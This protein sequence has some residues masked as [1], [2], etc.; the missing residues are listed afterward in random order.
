MRQKAD[1]IG[2]AELAII[3]M[4]K[5]SMI[6][7]TGKI[8]WSEEVHEQRI[9]STEIPRLLVPRRS[10]G[11]YTATHYGRSYWPILRT[12]ESWDAEGADREDGDKHSID[13]CAEW[14]PYIHSSTKIILDLPVSLKKVDLLPP[15]GGQLNGMQAICIREIEESIR[16]RERT[17]P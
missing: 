11:Q 10:N 5:G 3:R 12:V 9:T 13:K 8:T 16:T 2:S 15:E 1:Y 4:L 14:T 6:G 7:S 17:D